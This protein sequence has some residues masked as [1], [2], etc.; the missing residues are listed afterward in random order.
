MTLP[1]KISFL[2]H[3]WIKSYNIF[4]RDSYNILSI[5]EEEEKPIQKFKGYT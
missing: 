2:I 1:L 5:L 4:V 3:V